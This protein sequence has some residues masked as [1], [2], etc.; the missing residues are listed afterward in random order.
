MDKQLLVIALMVI[1]V[2]FQEHALNLVQMEIGVQL[3]ALVMVF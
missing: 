1:M 3:L 2:Q